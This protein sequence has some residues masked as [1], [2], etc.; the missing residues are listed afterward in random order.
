MKPSLTDTLDQFN[1]CFTNHDLDGVMTYFADDSEYREL[2]GH[3]AKGKK[4]IRRSFQRAFDGAYG[5]MKFIG[6]HMIVDEE[7]KEASFVWACQHSFD[8]SIAP[9]GINKLL[10]KAL[11]LRYGS[12]TYWDGIDYFIFDKNNKIVSKQSYGNTSMPKFI[13]GRYRSV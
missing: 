6:K 10:A 7:K 12:Q 11:K 13:K 9:K 2:G 3:V 4:A 5:R 1:Q 8:D